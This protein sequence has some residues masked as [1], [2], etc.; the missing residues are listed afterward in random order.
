MRLQTDPTVIYG[1]GPNFKGPLKRSHLKK[2]TPY[3]TYTRNGLPPGPISL[4][5][6]AALL[7][8]VNPLATEDLYF[9]AKGDGSHKFSKTLKE[10]NRAVKKYRQ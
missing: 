9:M 3:N 1:L 8:A 10:H 5:G 6:R 7:A 2:D 4:P